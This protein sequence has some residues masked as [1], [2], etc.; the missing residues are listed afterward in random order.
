MALKLSL[1]MYLFKQIKRKIF[2]FIIEIVNE[3][4]CFHK[5]VHPFNQFFLAT[6]L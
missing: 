3:E 4:G 5:R 6:C 2:N 1:I